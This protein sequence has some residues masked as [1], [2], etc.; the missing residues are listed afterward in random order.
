MNQ[1]QEDRANW[2]IRPR[3]VDR[4]T[5]EQYFSA[6][7]KSLYHKRSAIIESCKRCGPLCNIHPVI[8]INADRRDMSSLL[9]SAKH[10]VVEVHVAD[11]AVAGGGLG[12][13]ADPGWGD[14]SH[15]PVEL[16]RVGM[17]AGCDHKAASPTCEFLQSSCKLLA[18]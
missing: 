4:C 14:S 9:E 8:G 3:V 18:D 11:Q 12:S 6:P 1:R 2:Q 13:L 16:G 10:R 5:Y 17:L 15:H 7:C